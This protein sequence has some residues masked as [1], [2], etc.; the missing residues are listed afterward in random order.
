MLQSK[1]SSWRNFNLILD[2]DKDL[3]GSLING[4]ALAAKFGVSAAW[5]SIMTFTTEIYPTVVR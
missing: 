5:A 1:D 3:Q 4:F 2:V